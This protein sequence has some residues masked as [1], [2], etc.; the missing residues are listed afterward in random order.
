MK[1]ALSLVSALVLAGCA[2]TRV[3]KDVSPGFTWKSPSG[4]SY[5][6]AGE[7][8]KTVNTGAFSTDWTYQLSVSANGR[9]VISGGLDP[10]TF[11]GN[12][13]GK[14]DGLDSVAACVGTRKS[15][16]W[17]DVSCDIAAGGEK[18][19]VLKF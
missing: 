18:I 3:D 16:T 14:I 17:V 13:P 15:P 10:Y 7:I 19:G 4:Q 11:N 5:F 6:V 9:T 1:L 8:T 2:S 12:V